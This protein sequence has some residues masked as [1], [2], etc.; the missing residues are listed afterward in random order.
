MWVLERVWVVC[1]LL[2]RVLLVPACNVL[3]C[4]VLLLTCLPEA[5]FLL[6]RCFF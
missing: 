3:L 1:V 2:V 4:R 6:L 5:A